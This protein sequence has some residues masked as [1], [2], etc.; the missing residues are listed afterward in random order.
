M[1]SSYD[2][3]TNWCS[4]VMASTATRMF[5]RMYS[6]DVLVT[7]I[8]YEL[9]IETLSSGLDLSRLSITGFCLNINYMC[10]VTRTELLQHDVHI[11]YLFL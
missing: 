10:H 6:C 11:D 4:K 2:F 9:L 3:I 1:L 7:I 8:F 5:T